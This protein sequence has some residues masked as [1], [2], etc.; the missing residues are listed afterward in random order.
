MRAGARAGPR[1]RRRARARCAASGRRG[2]RGSD[3]VGAWRHAFLAAPYLRDT[4]VACGVL[5]ETFETAITWDRFADFHATVIEAARRAVAEVIG[6]PPRASGAA[7]HRCRFTHVYPDGPAPYF[8]ILAPAR[9]GSEVEQWDEIKAAVSEAVID[10]GGTI[11]HHHA[12][13]RDHRPW[14]D[15]QRPDAFAE[16]LRAAKRAVD[17]AGI[18]NPGVLIDPAPPNLPR[19]CRRC[20]AP[21]ARRSG[22]RTCSSSPGCCSRAASTRR[23]RS[24]DAMLT[25]VA[26][27]AISSAGYLLNDLRDRDARPPA[28]PRSATAR[29]P[30]ARVAPRD[31]GTL[32]VALAVAGDR[33]R[34]RGRRRGRRPRRP[35]RRD[36]HRLL[37]DPEA[38]GD[39]RRDDDRLAVHPPGGRRRGRGRRP[40]LGVP[41]RSAPGCSPSSSASPSAARRRCWRKREAEAD[42]PPGARALLAAV[43]RPDDRDGDRV[44][45]HQL[46]HLRGRLAAGSARRCWRRRRRCSTGSSATC[47]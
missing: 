21:C 23:A 44:G 20:S 41:A 37:A 29:S 30:A 33:A 40:R 25:F 1:P 42:D 38:A 16:A 3:A 10:A 24:V 18:L 11:T 4:L 17:P 28:T 22:S 5:S 31:R 43:P 19:P 32:A 8:T 46:R 36:H 34:L 45:D 6:A 47:T 14:Y 2:E 26:F 27:C 9:R 39:H 15:R 35:L 12:V 13:G 7:G